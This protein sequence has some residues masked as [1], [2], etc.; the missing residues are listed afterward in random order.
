M[1]HFPNLNLR[2]VV[3]YENNRFQEFAVKDMLA[4]MQDPRDAE[5]PAHPLAMNMIKVGVKK[6]VVSQALA[7]NKKIL[8]RKRNSSHIDFSAPAIEGPRPTAPVAS[9]LLALKYDDKSK[10]DKHLDG[11]RTGESELRPV[12]P[13]LENAE[14]QYCCD[15]DLTTV[16]PTA[17]SRQ[18]TT[19]WRSL[20]Q[21]QLSNPTYLQI[22]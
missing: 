1:E 22:A 11:C 12:P 17:R 6:K 21:E 3:F 20:T 2:F 5:L 18:V 19:S 16:L 15:V 8:G 10:R 7:A 14:G 4:S 13:S 9:N